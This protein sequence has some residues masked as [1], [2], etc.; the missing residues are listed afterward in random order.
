[1]LLLIPSRTTVISV[2][3]VRITIRRS[4]E[5]SQRRFM[6]RIDDTYSRIWNLVIN[7]SKIPDLTPIKY[8]L[9]EVFIIGNKR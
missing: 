2:H 1:M 8:R 4:V 6:D 9:S 5:K 3:H 7:R